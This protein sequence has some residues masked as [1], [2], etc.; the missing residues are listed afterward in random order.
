MAEFI[1]I[2]VFHQGVGYGWERPVSFEYFSAGDTGS[3][4]VDCGLQIQGGEGRRPEKSPKHSFRLV[5]KN[6]YGPTKLR[7]PFFGDDAVSVFQHDHIACR[8]RE[9]MDSLES[10]RKINGS[11]S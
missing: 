2:Q 7:Y 1:F 9:H 5:F 11:I 4:Q 3:F 8:I 10:Q 6:E